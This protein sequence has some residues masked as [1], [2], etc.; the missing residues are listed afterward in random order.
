L[1]EGLRERTEERPERNFFWLVGVNGEERLITTTVK[2]MA[3]VVRNEFTPQTE[4]NE[5][6]NIVVTTHVDKM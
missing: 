6:V 2:N 5:K 4:L 1:S 3:T